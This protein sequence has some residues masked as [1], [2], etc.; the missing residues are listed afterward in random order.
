MA[1]GEMRTGSKGCDS[2][3]I[4]PVWV[5]QI[6]TKPSSIAATI[7]DESYEST[8]EYTKLPFA[9]VCM[10]S[11]QATRHNCIPPKPYDAMRAESRDITMFEDKTLWEVSMVRIRPAVMVSQMLDFP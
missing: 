1:T 9:K 11:P 2:R 5:D 6:R 4:W 7:N 10:G 8:A 3:R